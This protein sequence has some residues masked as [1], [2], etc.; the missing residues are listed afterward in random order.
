MQSL[1]RIALQSA[2]EEVSTETQKNDHRQK[3]KGGKGES[4]RKSEREFEG[5]RLTQR[6]GHERESLEEN[7]R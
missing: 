5:E 7:G 3:E 6:R 1:K 4:G 2:G